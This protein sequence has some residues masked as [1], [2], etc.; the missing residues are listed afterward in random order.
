MQ[1][2]PLDRRLAAWLLTL[3]GPWSGTSRADAVRKARRMFDASMSDQEFEAALHR[4][5]YVLCGE[6]GAAFGVTP[7]IDRDAA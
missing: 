4:A 6:D 5:G 7:R 1:T 2:S 3:P